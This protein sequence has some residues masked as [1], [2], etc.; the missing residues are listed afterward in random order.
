[1]LHDWLDHYGLRNLSPG[2]IYKKIA[3]RLMVD[4]DRAKQYLWNKSRRA[5]VKEPK[6]CKGFCAKRLFC[7]IAHPEQFDFNNCLGQPNYDFIND[8]IGAFTNLL[9][10]EW[11]KRA[12]PV[13][14]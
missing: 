14:L 1:M 9:T 5:S 2:E 7:E 11:V 12:K 3:E 6:E 13:P 4:E 8:P 10:A